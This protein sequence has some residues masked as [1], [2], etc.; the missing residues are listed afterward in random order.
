MTPPTAPSTADPPAV[1]SPASRRAAE[2]DSLLALVAELAA[3]DLGRARILALAPYTDAEQLAAQRRRVEEATHLLQAGPLVSGFDFPVRELLDRMGSARPELVGLDLVRIADLL[4]AARAAARRV[5]EAAGSEG[6]EDEED[7]DGGDSAASG[8]PGS[9]EAPRFPELAASVAA[10]PDASALLRKI[11]GALDRRGDV[12]EN[13][14]PRL[15]EARRRI[16]STRDSLYGHLSSYVEQH[17]SDLSEETV[18]LRGGRL[19]LVLQAGSKG[20]VQGLTHGRSGSGKSFYFEPLE[21]V[22]ENNTLQQA[23]EEEEEERRRIIAELATAVREALDDVEA[24]AELLG[25]LDAVQAA[26]RFARTTGGRLA[27]LA[28]AGELALRGARHP[29]LTPELADLRAA[30]LGSPGHRD[31]VIPLDLDLEPEIR[32]LVVTGPNAGG[33]TVALKTVGLLTLAHQCGLPVPAEQGTRLPAVSALVATVGDDQDL[34][35]EQ[36]T[37]SGRLLRLREAWEAAGPEAL[38]LL[39]ELGS[40]TDPEEGSALAIS[41]LEGLLERRCLAVITTHLTQLAAAALEMDGAACAAMEF[42]GA[43]GEPTYRLLPGPPGASEAL[44]LARRLGLPAAWLDRAEERLGTEHL[45]LRRMIA[46]V[47][48][49][50]RELADARARTERELAGLEREREEMTRQRVELEGETKRVAGRMK[51]ELDRF[52]DETR[53]KFRDEVERIVEEVEAGRKKGLASEATDRA[54]EEAPEFPEAEPEGEGEL[55]EGVRV[56]HKGFGWEG[57][58]E[59]LDRGRAEVNVRGKKLRCKADELIPLGEDKPKPEKKRPSAMRRRR[60]KDA[61]IDTQA[62]SELHLLG[63]RVEEALNKV[64]DYL[65]QALLASKLQVRIVHGHGTGRLKKAV[66][67]HLRGHPAV[68]AFRPGKPD[69]GGDGATVVTLKGG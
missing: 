59:S 22:E 54:F 66:R 39:D 51:A 49:V 16:R 6:R 4:K 50:R 2:L 36:S 48:E 18:P 37:F 26:V 30:A 57:E 60:S 45:K 47:E 11:D 56:R 52:R 44:A 43:T 41:L 46:E 24:H 32:C 42:S 69:E 27:E 34:L 31:E 64:D 61:E 63:L 8:D 14:S 20:R 40:G 9:P 58:L 53:K 55:R 33:K 38:I 29:L 10:L 35:A 15:A 62:P 1:C 5:Q 19:V 67:E 23:T 7:E 12:K 17:R 68:D 28:P 65:D 13:A 25:M 3:T 21:V